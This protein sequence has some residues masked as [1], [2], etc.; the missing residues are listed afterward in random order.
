LGKGVV[1]DE[2][3]AFKYYEVLAKQE[4]ADAQYQLGNCFYHG[5]G[6]KIDEVQAK[7]WYEEAI[8]NG[9]IVAKDI[10][11]KYNNKRIKVEQNKIRDIKLQNRLS[12]RGLSQFGLNYFVTKFTTNNHKEKRF[13][14]IQRAIVN[15]FKMMPFEFNSCHKKDKDLRRNGREVY[16]FYKSSA[17]QG[18]TNAKFQ[19]GYC[20]DEG[21]GADISK[22]K[23]FD[24][25]KVIAEKGN[26]D[27]LYN[28]SLLY[29]LGEGVDKDEQK[30]FKI[31]EKL[32][33]KK[34]D[35]DAI[36]K[37]AY[38]YNKGI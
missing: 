2:N 29:E 23:A 15:E 35:L 3:K 30:A 5:I 1:K 37:L 33:E 32:A 22:V 36:Y 14:Y 28:L 34:G 17:E 38:Y 10:I 21:I 24:L 7:F 31:I 6:I 11:K 26:N 8:K 19:L 16:E 18:N 25:Y 9:N 4:I 27:A 20:Y 13:K 12:F